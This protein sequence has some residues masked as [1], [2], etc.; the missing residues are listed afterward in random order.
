MEVRRHDQ[1]RPKYRFVAQDISQDGRRSGGRGRLSN[2]RALQRVW[3]KSPSNR[4]NVGAIGIGRIS[5]VH[6][7]PGIWQ[8]DSARIIAV[9]DLDANRV[10][11]GKKLVNS[12]YGRKQAGLRRCTGYHDTMTCWRI[13][14][15]M[16]S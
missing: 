11:E 16:P 7:L 14:I 1:K 12:Y 3:R 15:S 13:K 8:F 9:S 2:D 5:R 10:E 6:D 4:I